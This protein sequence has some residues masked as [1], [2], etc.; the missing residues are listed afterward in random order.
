MKIVVLDT[1][2]V[3]NGDI[4]LKEIEEVGYT[5]YY[6]LL[7]KEQIIEAAKDADAIICN[8]AEITEDIMDACSKLKYVGV[9]ATGYNNIDLKAAAKKGIAVANVPGYST[10]SVAMLTFAMIL[11][12]ATSFS[13][14]NESVKK[15]EW[16][17]SL[18]FSYFSFPVSELAGKTLGI[19]GYGNIGKQVGRIG[20]AFGMNVIAYNRSKKET[21]HVRFVS[22]EELFSQSDYLSMHC[23]LTQ[24]TA[25][26]IN[27]NTLSEMK[28]TAYLINTSRGGVIVEEDLAYALNNDLIAGAG[29]DVLQSEPMIE[30]HPYLNAK[31][32][33]ITPHIGWAAIEARVRLITLVAGNIRS[34]FEGKP[35]NIVNP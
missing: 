30:N 20:N 33:L 14:Y 27:I 16:V 11:E 18:Q 1:C 5:E 34:F 12:F 28:K 26:I 7:D 29:I 32:C 35:I 31:N 8:K 3:T 21:D 6:D 10:D 13:R 15:G 23:P 17:R 22:K 9:F 24:E 2:T 25:R 19:F 4:S